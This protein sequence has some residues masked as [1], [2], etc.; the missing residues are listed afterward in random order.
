MLIDTTWLGSAKQGLLLSD[1]A[2]AYAGKL[3]RGVAPHAEVVRLSCVGSRRML[4]M[5]DGGEHTL[6]HLDERTRGLVERFYR[7]LLEQHGGC[8]RPRGA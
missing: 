7:L 4:G 5:R 1:R 2:C 8:S 6:P 3:T